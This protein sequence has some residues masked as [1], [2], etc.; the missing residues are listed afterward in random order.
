MHE[1]LMNEAEGILAWIIEG[2]QKWYKSGLGNPAFIQEELSIY[3]AEMDK[4]LAMAWFSQSGYE[5][6]PQTSIQLL[7]YLGEDYGLIHRLQEFCGK[8]R[9]IDSWNREVH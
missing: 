7:R 5:V 6:N 2:A 8:G 3:E 1:H 9:R 4:H